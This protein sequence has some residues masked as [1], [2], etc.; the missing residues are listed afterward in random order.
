MRPTEDSGSGFH[1]GGPAVEPP[2][3][4]FLRSAVRSL[5]RAARWAACGSLAG[6]AIPVIF[7]GGLTVARFFGGGSRGGPALEGS[8]L[9]REIWGWDIVYGVGWIS[10]LPASLILWAAVGLALGH[11]PERWRGRRR[12]IAWFAATLAALGI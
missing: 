2:A 11:L 7:L 5:G 1:A 10:T 4:T 6:L 8:D 9:L 3:G 12:R